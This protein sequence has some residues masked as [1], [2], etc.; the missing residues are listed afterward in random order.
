[1]R[2]RVRVVLCLL[3]LLV[4]V[5]CRKPLTPNIDRN[6]AP[7]TWITAAPRDTLTLRD[8]NGRPIDIEIGN[9]IIPVR[10]HMYWAGSDRDGS[11]AGYY[12]AVTET[13]VTALEG[14]GIP[15]LPG[16][17]PQD[18]RFTT[19]TDTTFVF[20][21]SENAPDR[22]HAF[23]LYAVDN[24]GK[25]DPT[26]ARFAFIAIDKF[27]PRPVIEEA[28]ATG[29]IV[30]LYPDG[31]VTPEVREYFITDTLPPPAI[32]YPPRDTVPT[33]SRLD[34]R[35]HGEITLA[36]TYVTRYRYKLDEP[37]FVSGD[38]SVHAVSYNTG[39]PGSPVISPGLKVFTLR[40]LDQAGGAGET[41]RRFVMNF[42]PDT[43]W[44]GPD[45]N[46]FPLSSDQDGRAADITNW[47]TLEGL[48]PGLFFGPDSLRTRPSQRLPERR[49]FYEIYKNRIYARSEGETVHL[50]SWVVFW[51]GGY[52]QDS[53]YRVK[54]DS[55][56]PD[57]PPDPGGVNLATQ[58]AG[59]VGSPIGFR[60]MLAMRF[61]PS[62]TRGLPTQSGLYPVYEPVSVFRAPR[63]G[64]YWRMFF[65]G[66]MYV[67]AKAEDADAALDGTVVD[68]VTLADRVDGG[69]GT[70]E[71]RLYRRKVLVFYANKAPVL[72]TQNPSFRP[73][74]NQAIT[75]NLW[76]FNLI[77]T[78]SDPF[79]TATES[80][81]AGGPTA[82]MVIRY[83]VTLSGTA[84]NGRD[85][86]WTY[87][88]GGLP[89]IQTA[90]NAQFTFVP[91]QPGTNPF[92]SGR[93]TVA[94]QTC[95]CRDCE[96]QPGQGR[97]VDNVVRV[98]YTRPPEP[99]LE[100]TS[101]GGGPGPD[102]SGGRQ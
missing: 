42:S 39:L 49:T 57:L 17:K 82:S 7:E 73:F 94:I 33:G 77:G 63:I 37:Q 13:T 26:P 3:A 69:G 20:N 75:T 86:S 61:D 98:N 52:D 32:P 92:A 16:P 30:V 66:K 41:T 58:K 46:A 31:S 36:G 87:K 11:I 76:T 8:E 5:G 6:Q 4:G 14:L 21:V 10:F 81:P 72:Q 88:S 12:W 23:F 9:H 99:G 2:F 102:A 74:E 85:T 71:E 1:M 43:W 60:S 89:Y 100:P 18:Y 22:Q 29:T 90:G 53:E 91:G 93:I 80:P 54:A 45:V 70:P 96:T 51:N 27:P 44:A 67:T 35:W 101:I 25:P 50:N 78:D 40:A 84:T 24:Q 19:R 95:D 62:L 48:P 15:P 79:D 97:C 83:K 28:K 59:L 47:N 56:D 34:F 65:S 64:G 68:P 38:S 55:T